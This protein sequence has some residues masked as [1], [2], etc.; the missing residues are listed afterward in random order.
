MADAEVSEF[1]REWIEPT[2]RRLLG[3]SPSGY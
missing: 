1:E 3:L 2:M